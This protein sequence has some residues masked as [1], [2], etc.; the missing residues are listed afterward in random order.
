V[1]VPNVTSSTTTVAILFNLLGISKNSLNQYPFRIKKRIKTFIRFI[2][3]IN[4]KI[5]GFMFGVF[6]KPL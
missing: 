3:F 1:V 6:S 5:K 2:V 4:N